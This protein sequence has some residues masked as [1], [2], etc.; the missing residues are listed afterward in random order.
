MEWTEALARMFND[1]D[2]DAYRRQLEAV[3]EAEAEEVVNVVQAQVDRWED[4]R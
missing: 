2:P 3:R 1:T 4:E